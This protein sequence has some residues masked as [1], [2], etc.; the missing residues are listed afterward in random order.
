MYL[1]YF[2]LLLFSARAFSFDT[3]KILKI[4]EEDSYN[5]LERKIGRY[6]IEHSSSFDLHLLSE[7]EFLENIVYSA[8]ARKTMPWGS[9]IPERIFL[10]Y[11]APLRISQERLHP[12][13]S[14]FFR[15]FAPQVGNCKSI[16]DAAL[17]INAWLAGKVRYSPSD[18]RDLDP[19][20][21]LKRGFGRCEEVNIL[22]IAALRSVGIPARNVWVPAWRHTRGNHAWVEVYLDDNRWHYIDPSWLNNDFDSAWFTPYLNT[23][24]AVLTLSSDPECKEY[25]MSKKDKICVITCRYAREVELTVKI[26]KPLKATRI[27]VAIMNGGILRPILT[28]KVISN[29]TVGFCLTPGNYV[30][31]VSNASNNAFYRFVRLT[32]DMTLEFTKPPGAFDSEELTFCDRRIK[33]HS[34]QP[35]VSK[36]LNEE[37]LKIKKE[38][39]YR[40]NVLKRIVDTW[41]PDATSSVRRKLVQTGDRLFEIMGLYEI[42][43]SSQRD[44]FL[45]FVDVINSKD[46]VDINESEI[47][48]HLR[49][50]N[51]FVS[52]EAFSNLFLNPRI[53]YEPPLWNYISLRKILLK[54]RKLDFFEIVKGVHNIVRSIRVSRDS[55]LHG[56]LSPLEV[57]EYMQAPDKRDVRITEVALFRAGGIPSFYVEYADDVLIFDGMKWL[58]FKYRSD[59]DVDLKKLKMSSLKLS[60]TTHEGKCLKPKDYSY[61]RNFVLYKWNNEQIRVVNNLSYRY[62]DKSCTYEFSVIPGRYDLVFEKSRSNDNVCS[63]LVPVTLKAGES[64][65][66]LFTVEMAGLL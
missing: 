18:P 37:R 23:V 44:L 61:Y 65:N 27:Y 51:N 36:T 38:H 1:F 32:E 9:K 7:D 3:I 8:L 53:A 62:D 2:L 15:L 20:S 30:V 4:L 56:G 19:V 11:V 42:L 52:S 59:G 57:I 26:E 34:K 16:R 31:I 6:L 35:V 50:C 49:F 55:L 21:I 14:T 28:Q 66:L 29:H 39:T 17:K 5:S 25:K 63:A 12:W 43:S 58:E 24:P 47:I 60:F 22:Y 48:N 13:R 10:N 45:K 64:K 41:I 40:I 46:L 54:N 33:I